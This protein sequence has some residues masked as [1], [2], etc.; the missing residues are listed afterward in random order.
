VDSSSETPVDVGNDV[1]MT[2]TAGGTPPPIRV[3]WLDDEQDAR[4]TNETP[5]SSSQNV[6]TFILCIKEE[7]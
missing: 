1:T 5:V 6:K 4:F 2:C 7:M 3:Y